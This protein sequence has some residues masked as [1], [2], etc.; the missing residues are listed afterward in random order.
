MADLRLNSQEIRKIRI[1]EKFCDHVFQCQKLTYK[2]KF[3]NFRPRN[4]RK[5]VEKNSKIKSGI[6]T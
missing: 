2:I 4:F 5:I 3:P 6:F 1:L